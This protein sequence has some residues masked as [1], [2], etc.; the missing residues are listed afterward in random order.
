MKKLILANTLLILGS[1]SV[2]LSALEMVIGEEYVKPGIDFIFEGAIKDHVMPLSQNLAEH[3]TD[4]HIEA[5]VNWSAEG[6]V[7]EGTPR[8][9]F[10]AYLKINAEVVNQKTKETT[11]V[12][13]TP[14]INLIDNLH[15]ARNISLPGEKGDKYTVTF[16][17]DP[18]QTNDLSLHKDWVESHH[19]YLL[20]SQEFTYK[21]LDFKEIAEATRK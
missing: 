19:P 17:I 9:G 21:D 14:H 15:Y 7:P 4:V 18:P 13:L 1:L 2:K 8:G 5:R 12:T 3:K 11:F 6:K 20:Q 10:V 16:F